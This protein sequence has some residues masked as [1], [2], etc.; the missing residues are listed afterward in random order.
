MAPALSRSAD[1]D[2]DR[3][4]AAATTEAWGRPHAGRSTETARR[5]RGPARA[6]RRPQ[7]RI[8]RPPTKRALALRGRA[9]RTP[10]ISTGRYV[11]GTRNSRTAGWASEQC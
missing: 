7:T 5:P 11:P 4:S 10:D 8:R 2:R 9:H 6:Y 1:A 3:D